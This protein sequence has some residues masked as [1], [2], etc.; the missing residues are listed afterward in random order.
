MREI[1]GGNNYVSQDPAEA[2]FGLGET[3]NI[4][5]IKI[6]WPDATTTIFE[7]IEADQHYIVER[8]YN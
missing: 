2:H 6:I 4:D 1:R 7:S 5:E 3:T 8:T